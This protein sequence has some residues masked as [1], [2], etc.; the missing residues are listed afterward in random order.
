MKST[1]CFAT[2]IFFIIKLFIRNNCRFTC[3]CENECVLFTR[4]LPV[5]TSCKT[6]VQ[7]RTR[8]L[9]LTQARY[10][11]F[12]RHGDPSCGP[13]TV[14]PTPLPPCLLHPDLTL[15]SISAVLSSGE[16]PIKGIPQHRVAGVAFFSFSLTLWGLARVGA[17][18]S[19][20]FL[21]TAESCPTWWLCHCSGR[22]PS[23]DIWV[24][25]VSGSSARAP[26]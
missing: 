12:C 19:N 5:V 24:S 23:E 21:L 8:I 2:S 18:V 22:C 9:A 16:H 20:L 7:C 25:P 1:K 6:I 17:P 11:T 4:S 3:S 10:R 15:S 26:P 13:F 14:T